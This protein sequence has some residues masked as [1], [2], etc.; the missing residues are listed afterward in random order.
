MIYIIITQMIVSASVYNNC[1]NDDDDD[2]DDDRDD[3]QVNNEFQR[4]MSVPEVMFHLPFTSKSNIH[5][6]DHFFAIL[7]ISSKYNLSYETML[8]MLKWTKVS[9][10]ANKLQTTTK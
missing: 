9:H 7:A 10:Y 2:E 1:Y 6:G 4:F 8:S 3:T 5:Q